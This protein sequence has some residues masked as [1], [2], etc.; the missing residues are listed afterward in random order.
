MTDTDTTTGLTP[1][2]LRT[3]LL[4]EGNTHTLLAECE[5]LWLH[6]KV[7][8]TGGE[9]GLHQHPTEDHAFVV[10]QGQA[11]FYDTDGGTKVVERNEGVLLPRGTL[12]RFHSTGEGNLVM[13]R[14]GAGVPPGQPKMFRTTDDGSVATGF[15]AQNR[16]GAIPG[17]PL[18]GQFFGD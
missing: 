16:T 17:V 2:S 8:A 11:T 3:P 4:S 10:L 14:A 5:S 6:V 15:D 18:P 7:Y 13:L 1:F 12:Y 9:N